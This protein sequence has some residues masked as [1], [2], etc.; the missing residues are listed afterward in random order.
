MNAK[1]EV[2]STGMDTVKLWVA[3]VLVGAGIGAFYFFDTQSTLLRVLGLLVVAGVSA[4][5]AMQTLAGRNLW[6]FASDAK[7]EVRKVV[8]PSRQETIQTTLV[9]LVMV[10]II[11]ILLWLVDMLLLTIVRALTGQGG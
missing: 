11:G 4:A 9:V 2:E 6:Q 1:T 3:A 10:L 8:W 7:L 5:I